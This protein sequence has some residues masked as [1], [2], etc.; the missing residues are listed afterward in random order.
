LEW[1]IG[2][3]WNQLSFLGYKDTI[4][5]DTRQLSLFF[6]LIIGFS[7]ASQ[8]VAQPASPEVTA[9]N[10]APKVGA[11][12][13]KKALKTIQTKEVAASRSPQDQARRA[14]TVATF[15]AGKITIGDLEDEI[16]QQSPMMRER[17]LMREQRQLL[18]EKMI[19]ME[20]LAREADK[21]GYGKDP[22]V[23]EG[24]KQNA[25]Q[26]MIREQID[27]QVTLESIPSEDVRKYYE[28]HIAEFVRPETRRVNH[29]AVA[30]REEA[31]QLIKQLQ[32]ADL[33]EFRKVARERSLDQSTKMRAG[34][35]GFFDKQAKSEDVNAGRPQVEEAVAK[36]AFTLAEVGDLSA[37]PIK[38]Q[39]GFSVVKLAGIKPGIS[40]NL[41][42]A[43]P[44][45]RKRLWRATREEK[46]KA[47]IAQLRGRTTPEVHPELT[48]AIQLESGPPGAD[49]MPGFPSAPRQSP[50]GAAEAS[51]TKR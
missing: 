43:E 37:K 3:L 16:A 23:N 21:R 29:I 28:E 41:K 5:M 8:A 17:Y 25:V 12:A 10:R 1:A 18:L 51:K 7:A 45:I 40:R 6:A 19:R 30:T 48:E 38:V 35:L 15:E 14:Q 39:G 32:S 36:A 50:P 24:V 13:T 34:D 47:F 49:L 22:D 46:M 11:A 33:K 27:G 44:T 4:A 20:M 9:T 26:T 42:E 2:S 31:Q